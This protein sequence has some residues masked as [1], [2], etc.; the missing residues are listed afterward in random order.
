MPKGIYENYKRRTTKYPLK[1]RVICN[2]CLNLFFPDVNKK[3]A[4]VE[5]P[6]C[7]KNVDIR[8]R[9]G[10]YKEYCSKYPKKA[11]KRLQA[12]K[13]YDNENK[14]E[15]GRKSRERLRIVILNIISKGNP[16]CVRCGCTDKRFL[17]IN[18]KNGGGTKEL[19]KKSNQFYWDIQTGKRNVDDL[20]ILCKVCNAWHALE[21]K[22][23]KLN[24]KINYA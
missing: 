23:G 6:F 18:H 3:R 19:R 22:Y 12:M 7:K 21:L 24:Y 14:K 13:K 4:N 17:E 15:R 11:F 2:Q 8:D 20:E 5:C 9:R 10:Y 1:N 16:K